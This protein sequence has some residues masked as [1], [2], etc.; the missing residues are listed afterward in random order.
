MERGR[1]TQLAKSIEDGKPMGQENQPE[2]NLREPNSKQYDQKTAQH[3]TF[4]YLS[5]RPAEIVSRL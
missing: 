2:V 5:G 3:C 4:V 1:K